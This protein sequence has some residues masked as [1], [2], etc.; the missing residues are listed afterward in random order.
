MQLTIPHKSAIKSAQTNKEN[1]FQNKEHGLGGVQKSKNHPAQLPRCLQNTHEEICTIPKPLSKQVCAHLYIF[2][3]QSEK[4]GLNPS[5]QALSSAI[6]EL[7]PG[8]CH[9]LLT[10]LCE[11][12]HG[13]LPSRHLIAFVRSIAWQS[14]ALAHLRPCV[15]SEAPQEL[16]SRDDMLALKAS[17]G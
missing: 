6:V 1:P 14:P 17:F 4:L 2:C 8:C 9:A 16:L 13:R 11:W 15:A 7:P 12:E 3:T 10:C 5:R